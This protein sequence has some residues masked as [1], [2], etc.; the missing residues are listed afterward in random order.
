MKVVKLEYI[1]E[2]TILHHIDGEGSL[3]GT[4]GRKVI[5][6][7]QGEI[8]EQVTEF[9]RAYPRDLFG[10]SRP[11]ARAMRADKANLYVNANGGLLGIRA[12]I[13]YT[14]EKSGAFTPWFEIQGDSVLHGGICE[15][16]QGWTYFGEYFMNPRR[17]EVHIFRVDP[18]LKTW[19]IAHTF[20]PGEIRH[21][22][23]V[24][25]DPYD[26]DS[27]WIT[28]GDATGECYLFRTRDRFA[29]IER[30]GEGTQRWRAVRLFFTPDAV[31]WLTD[32]QL[33]QNFSCRWD[34]RSGKLALGDRVDAPTWYGS[35]TVEGLHLAFTTVEP[36]PSVDRRTAA[37]FAS[38]DAVEWKEIY[39]FPKDQWR[40]MKLFKY[41]VIS[42]PSG[43]MSQNEF[44]ISGEGL[45]GL[46]GISARL[47]IMAGTT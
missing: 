29:T 24:Y 3:W 14:L 42:C 11:T 30:I 40:P 17:G 46:D 26:V 16:Q 33:E 23:G 4:R 36:G 8:W 34:R 35:T 6:A 37:I 41:G 20:S 5:K 18:E 12:G 25:R 15:D 19:E 9:P 45:K 21:I 44:L 38:Q 32:S 7:I 1:P 39:R 22:H 28:S 47:N 43:V 27:L 10:F 31:C 13:V 2:A